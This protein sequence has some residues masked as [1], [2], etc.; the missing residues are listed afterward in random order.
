MTKNLKF[1]DTVQGT[2]K[3]TST[4]ETGKL[5]SKIKELQQQLSSITNDFEEEKNAKNQAYYYIISSGNFKRFAEFCK[6]H[7]LL[8]RLAVFDVVFHCR[9]FSV[10]YLFY[11]FKNLEDYLR[12]HWIT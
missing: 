9:L 4:H 7:P 8:G 2:V 11:R 3:R 12:D 1:A 10:F 6:N 5:L